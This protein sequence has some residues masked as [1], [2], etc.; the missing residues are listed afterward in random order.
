MSKVGGFACQ[1][2]WGGWGGALFFMYYQINVT[3]DTVSEKKIEQILINTAW[4]MEAYEKVVIPEPPYL[5]TLMN[6]TTI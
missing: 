1:L 4:V 3:E 2:L 6:L 5:N